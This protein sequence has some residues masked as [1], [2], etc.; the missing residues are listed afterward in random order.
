[1]ELAAELRA[2]G[3]TWETAALQLRRQVGLL[4]RWS[5]NYREEWE[6]LFKDAE[7]RLSRQSGNE[8]KAVLRQL[9]RS[10][11]SKL[12]LAA[13]DKLTRLRLEEKTAEGPPDPHADLAAFVACAEEMSDDE[14]KEYLE[15]F[16]REHGNA[17]GPRSDAGQDSAAAAEG[18]KSA[19]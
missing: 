7:E 16:V 10:K 1:M 6:R 8:S 14:L 12:R 2:A 17:P 5:R 15:E 9:L 11:S 3:A 19:A 18:P 4:V 13:A